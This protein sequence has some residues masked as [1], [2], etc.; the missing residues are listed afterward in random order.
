MPQYVLRA[1]APIFAGILILIGGLGSGRDNSDQRINQGRVRSPLNE[2]RI[3]FL[4]YSLKTDPTIGLASGDGFVWHQ[5]QSGNDYYLEKWT[6]PNQTV[7]YWYDDTNI[8]MAEDTTA[9]YPYR[10]LPGNW[11]R[12]Y[13]RVGETLNMTSNQM[14][15][16]NSACQTVQDPV[17]CPYHNT[18]EAH[19]P[20]Y[21]LGGDLGLQDVIVLKYAWG[22]PDFANVERE[23]YARGYGIVK[24]E[25][26]NGVN[27]VAA[28][29]T[30]LIAHY[31]PVP[32][33]PTCLNFQEHPN[34][35]GR[36]HLKSVSNPLSLFIP[37]VFG[38]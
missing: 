11:A 7:H 34:S 8:Y 3:N 37:A 19:Y 25:W 26:W 32:I 4:S 21:D 13:M 36:T 30:N 1:S 28:V 5:I 17:D 20:E 6:N 10:F 27:L 2:T 14:Q 31:G 24:W 33:M 35:N 15:V 23:Y 38:T 12:R 22:A 18:L 9:R 16:L 29:T